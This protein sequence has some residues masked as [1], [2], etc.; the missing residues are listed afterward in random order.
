MK[1]N[2]VLKIIKYIQSVI[3]AFRG[4]KMTSTP[5]IFPECMDAD[6]RTRILPTGLL[7]NMPILTPE[8][9]DMIINCL[10]YM[11]DD[12]SAVI[13]QKLR[14]SSGIYSMIRKNKIETT[15][16][17]QLRQTL[18]MAIAERRY[19]T[20]TYTRKN[21]GNYIVEPYQIVEYNGFWYLLVVENGVIKKFNLD[22][23]EDIDMS[24]QC[25]NKSFK[26]IKE[27]LDEACTIWFAPKNP[28]LAKLEVGEKVAKYFRRRQIFPAQ[29]ILEIKGNGNIVITAE[30]ANK[31]D[32]FEQAGRWI[33]FIS[34][35]EPLVY[36]DF[37]C[38][39][40]KQ[41]LDVNL[42]CARVPL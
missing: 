14:Q 36:R 26:E 41:T 18:E 2:T 33:P 5:N 38:K 40:A 15:Y 34:V 30:F 23:V 25:F 22:F 24:F 29:S 28:E 21:T 7:T 32:F 12:N 31:E 35:I 6:D 39:K 42:H 10:E 3:S 19:V 20:F 37:I 17:L 13:I 8:E 4:M 27:K 1:K 11:V 16:A 9:I